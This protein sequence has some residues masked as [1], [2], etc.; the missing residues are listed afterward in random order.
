MNFYKK[1]AIALGAF[2]SLLFASS[3]YASA[4]PQTPAVFETYLANAEGTSDTS[5]TLATN[6]LRDGNFLIGYTC[7]TVDSNT[8]TLEY[9]CGTVS[10][11]TVSNLTRGIDAQTG[12]TTVS[13]LI[14]AHRRG[15][16]VKVTDY[17]TLTIVQRIMQGIDTLPVIINYVSSPDYTNASSSAVAS[18]GYVDGVALSGAPNATTLVKGIVQLA[19]GLQAASSTALGST[20]ASVVVPA[21]IATDTPNANTSSS[22]VLMSDLTGHLKQGWL[23]LTAAFSVSGTWTFTNAVSIVANAGHLLTLN[24]VPYLFPASQG[25]AGSKLTDD[26][27]GNLS[28]TSGVA[29]YNYATSTQIMATAGGSATSTSIVIPAGVMGA[30][31][32]IAIWGNGSSSNST[33]GGCGIVIADGNTVLASMGTPAPGS[34]GGNNFIFNG[35][36]E[37]MSSLTVQ[38]SYI[39]GFAYS[40]GAQTLAGG[41][42]STDNWANAITL[43]GAIQSNGSQNCFLANLYMVVTP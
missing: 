41:G 9:E 42:G 15:A 17:P 14:F 1:L 37:A 28:W 21:S 25:G 39:N 6:A 8:S 38:S 34:G 43:H 18:K 10:G 5:M 29:H 13:A 11:T 16:D 19:T 31:S 24:T 32:T 40:N 36:I 3:V 30:S 4:I 26:G 33:T 2:A 7:F 35:T 27:A 12:T 20:G 23:D 22:R